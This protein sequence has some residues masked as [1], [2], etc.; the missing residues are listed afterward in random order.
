MRSPKGDLTSRD[1]AE[2]VRAVRD[3]YEAFEQ[4]T[5]QFR[6]GLWRQTFET[7]SFKRNFEA[8]DELTFDRIIPTTIQG[9]VDRVSSKSYI[10]QLP[11]VKRDALAEE[12]QEYLVEDTSKT[13]IDKANG[14][15]EYPYKTFVVVMRK[16]SS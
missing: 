15:F 3:K 16:K 6:L 4:G 9:V 1:G 12:V 5:P 2:W 14:I 7:D 10:T 13:W 8:Q 11:E